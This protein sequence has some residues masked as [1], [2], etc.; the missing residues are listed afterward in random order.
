MYRQQVRE[1]CSRKPRYKDRPADFLYRDFE[2]TGS[3]AW[4]VSPGRSVYKVFSI[5]SFVDT[6]L[7]I[8]KSRE[9]VL[10]FRWQAKGIDARPIYT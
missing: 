4:T 2:K 8:A 9:T 5:N 6:M 3:A 7:K 1:K 10:A